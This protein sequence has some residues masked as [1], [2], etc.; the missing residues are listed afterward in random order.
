M[1]VH[2]DEDYVQSLI[3]KGLRLFIE[4]QILQ[5]ENA[6]QLP[7]HF[8]GSIAHFLKK[9]LEEELESFDLKLG[10]ILKKPIEGLV[11]YHLAHL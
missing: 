9:E 2:K 11:S 4:N 6:K 10:K 3:R 8:I 1:I 5:F 7:I